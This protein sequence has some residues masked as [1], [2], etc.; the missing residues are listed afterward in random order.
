MRYKK[1]IYLLVALMYC[2]Y[3][4]YYY[5]LFIA[6]HHWAAYCIYS[7]FVNTTGNT[8]GNV[9]LRNILVV[10]KRTSTRLEKKNKHKQS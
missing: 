6:M 4:C 5:S 10:N 1:L 8:K 3:S 7:R 9:L 2:N